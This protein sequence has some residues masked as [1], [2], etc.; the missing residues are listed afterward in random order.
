MSQNGLKKPHETTNPPDGGNQNAQP[1]S[2][3]GAKIEAVVKAHEALKKAEAALADYQEGVK[4]KDTLSKI[5][6]DYEA[7]YPNLLYDQDQLQDYH[8]NEESELR[9]ILTPEGVEKINDALE[10]IGAEIKKIE[11]RIENR[12]EELACWRTRLEKERAQAEAAK[13]EFEAL[14]KPAASIKDRLKK[15]DT[16]KAEVEKSHRAGDY[17]VAFW[18]LTSPAKLKGHL[19]G[20]PKVVPPKDLAAA[21]EKAR[22]CYAQAAAEAD[23]LDTKIRAGEKALKADQE[24][25]A[26]RRKSREARIIQRLSEIKPPHSQQPAVGPEPL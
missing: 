16:V 15:A 20:K 12:A 1:K 17:A 7:E 23:T 4:L 19:D 22:K 5:V 25:L 21:V 3:E 26:E 10:G 8:T 2:D 14:K 6:D 13:A 9:A 24:L 18:L 11:N